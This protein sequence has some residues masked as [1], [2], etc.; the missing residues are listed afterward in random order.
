MQLLPDSSALENAT[1]EPS[2]SPL[3]PLGLVTP[4]G[5]RFDNFSSSSDL[6]F[7]GNA[8][9]SGNNLQLTPATNTQAGSAFYK[10]AYRIDGSSNF[11]TQFQFQLSGGDGS[12]GADGF[13]FVIQNDGRGTG[14]IGGTGG[15]V[16]YSDIGRSLAIEF[17]TYDNGANDPDANHISL[18]RNGN[19]S[20]AV[21]NATTAIDLNGGSPIN[22]WIDYNAAS[23]QLSVFLA[24]NGP[25][26]ATAV[27]TE[28]VDLAATVGTQAYFGFTGGTGGLRNNQEIRSW[29]LDTNAA[30]I[31]G[32][33]T[34]GNGNGLRGEYFDNIDFTNSRLVR[35]DRTVDFGW[36]SGSPD[37]SIAADTFSVRW[38]GKVQP[39]YTEDYTFFTTVDDGVRL[40][41]NGQTV[42]NR[43]VDQPATTINGTPIRL[44][45][46][47][48]Y[49]I[50]L[51][52]YENRGQAVARLG[53]Q[54]RRQSRQIIPTSQLFSGATNSPGVFEVD[55][56]AVSVRENAGPARVRINRVGGSQGAASIQYITT[57]NTAQRDS[58]FVFQAQT[59]NFASGQTTAIVEIPIINDNVAEPTE[60]FIFGILSPTGAGLG[61]KRTV[62]VTI[63]DDDAV[64]GSFEFNQVAYEAKENAGTATITVNRVGSTTGAAAVR[65][66]TGAGTATAG[67]DYTTVSNVLNFANG[68]ASKTFTVN[69]VNDGSVERDETVQLTLSDATGAALGDRR[70]TL[71]SILNDDITGIQRE[72]TI[73]GLTAPT[74][75]KWTPNGDYVFIAQQNGEVKIA[76]ARTNQVLGTFI[77]LRDQVN[78]VRDRGLLGMT[79]DPQFANG[80]PYVYLLFTYDPP[81]AG[82]TSRPGYNNE[83]S[84]KDQTGNRPARLIR[85]E[86]EF[87]NGSYREK[88]GGERRILLGKNSN[89]ANTRGFDQNSTREE[90]RDL[91]ASGFVRDAQGNNTAESIQDYL[92][93]D[94]E[95][96]SVGDVEFG[97][98]GKLYVTIGDGT[99]Y[100][101][102]DKRT[103]R[104]QDIDN[105]SGKML[106]IDPDTGRGLADNPFYN[107]ST[108]SQFDSKYNSNLDSNRSKVFNLGLRNPFR[109]GFN[110]STGL[111]VIGDVGF[112]SWEELNAG[113][114]RN[115]GW[116]AYEGGQTPTGAPTSIR[117]PGY[118]DNAEVQPYY[119]GGSR[120]ITPTNPLYSFPHINRG[121]AVV[122]GEYY[123]GNTLPDRYDNALFFA[124][125]SQGRVSALFSDS[126]GRTTGTQLVEDNLFGVVQ[127]SVG[128]DGSLY[129][130]NIGNGTGTGSIGR[131]KPSTTAVNAPTARPGEFIKNSGLFQQS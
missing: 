54:S 15:A 110:P 72:T 74:S 127:L 91:P 106:R 18:L 65:Y 87:V 73:T 43:L 84:G 93:G 62:N 55:G 22:A 80:R 1:V 42:I 88:V 68:E 48:Q 113:R 120:A 37:P 96:H 35:T 79:I 59:V 39:L 6:Q 38:T 26:P 33:V 51:D 125:T 129:Y 67:T 123:M 23:K 57:N 126:Q 118:R 83:F 104:V 12:N 71:L 32:G 11:N 58:D 109:F 115:F 14:A 69:L 119:P 63:E 36:G 27:L 29:V 13:T 4:T 114:G 40:T 2:P 85:V 19:V 90:F 60:N 101:Y 105:L 89:F 111:P 31:T 108:G 56:A 81:E 82:Q 107:V 92:A 94:S 112:N 25:K 75:I 98:D 128:P 76:N 52:Y 7:N 64:N 131:W 86:A 34:P 10:T 45:A 30:P 66:S 8:R 99:S 130:V 61:T 95:S 24:T 124:N 3:A 102:N 117:T 21:R 77:D 9:Q 53:W 78:G 28:T 116:P 47:K 70:Q 97:P 41:V 122:M 50:A 44:E 100:I 46:G 20:T 17:D 16:G 5:F 49:D 121:N 103:I